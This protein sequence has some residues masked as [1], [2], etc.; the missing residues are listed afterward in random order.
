[1]PVFRLVL[2]VSL[3][4]HA[5][6]NGNAGSAK[7]KH[8]ND[9]AVA[10]MK[11]QLRLT[12]GSAGFNSVVA[13]R[14]YAYAGLTLY[15]SIAQQMP[16]LQ[17]IA[18]QLSGSLILPAPGS[19]KTYYPP[20]CANAAMAVISK[21]LF[22]KTTPA[23]LSAIDSLEAIFNNQFKGKI[24]DDELQ[25]SAEYGKAIAVAIAEWS[26]SDGGHAAYDS[27]FSSTY[28]LAVG[29]GKW[30]STPPAFI[31]P[32]HPHWGGNRSFLAGMAAASQPG[33]PPAYSEQ[34]GS[35]FYEAAKEIYDIS[36]KL[37]REDSVTARFW[38]DL[39]GNYWVP[40]HATHILTQMVRQQN[41]SLQDA[42]IIYC[43]HGLACNEGQISCFVTKYQYLVPR[44]VT[45]IRS[46]MGKTA[47]NPAIGTPPHPE[48]TSAHAVLSYG[49]ASVLED[50]FGANFSFT[51]S[52]YADS[53]GVRQFKSIAEYAEQATLSRLIG[54]IH[55]R[56]SADAGMKQGKKIGSLINA[57]KF[58]R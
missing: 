57:L 13:A 45:Y 11:L 42:A 56:F 41:L 19:G 8:S 23:L 16:E 4:I 55:Y 33:P 28:V 25:R 43:K 22:A 35:V 17:S 36:Q 37:T 20:A 46:V 54:G 38:A 27:I 5:S 50:A 34:P 6:R 3:I 26:K 53:Y 1:M 51:D 49:M 7:E 47:W 58:K 31:K 44:P 12:R 52:T 18:S 24:P 48:Y 32:V 2:F 10:W 14:S 39:P 21:T 40:A 30:V 15:E 29:Q 9:V